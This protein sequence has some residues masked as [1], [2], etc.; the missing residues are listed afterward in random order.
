M[1]DLLNKLCSLNGTSGREEKIREFIISQIQGK[2]EY[3]V[4]PL[5]NIIAFKKGEKAPKGRI[6]LDAHMDEVGFIITGITDDGFLKFATVGG[7]D[8]KVIVGRECVVGDK[9]IN[10]V[11][12][13][14]PIHLVDKE[15]E[16]TAPKKDDLYIDIGANSKKEAEEYV[17]PGDSAYFKGDFT[18][19]GSGFI[20]A[21]A[22]DDR[23]GCLILINLIN[24]A[25]EYDTYFT[26]TVQE[27]V[28]LRGA[29]AACYA[30]KPDYALIIETTTAADVSGIE[31][32][33][34][35]C[36]P[37]DGPVISFMDGATVYDREMFS[38]AFDV[39]KNS[40]IKCQAKT[41]VAGGNNAGAVHKSLCGIRTLALSL[42]CRY[43]H[44]PSCVISESDLYESEKL[45][46]EMIKALAEK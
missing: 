18:A 9:E 17:S 4:D 16:L 39:A 44:S 3:S 14:K 43:L 35:V 32:C 7:I 1:I 12:G 21:K 22:L 8:E 42:P 34:R 28:G 2:C 13:I 25:L 31:G 45:V 36:V 40:G 23:A 20:K 26:F 10:G 38:L 27:E 24:S 15:D 19:L 5:G 11:F 6:M 30:V 29:G 46:R 33:D 41:R 37:G